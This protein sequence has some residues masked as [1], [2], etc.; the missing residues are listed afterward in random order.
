MLLHIG[1]NIGVPLERVLFVLNATGMTPVTRAYLERARRGRRYL[2]CTGK[3]KCYVVVRERGKERVY[4][5]MIASSTLEK[6]WR[7]EISRR[8]LN[9]VAVL[10]VTEDG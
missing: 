8:Y 2:A 4:A 6:R 3:P 9:H 7:D 10:T 5:S 1:E